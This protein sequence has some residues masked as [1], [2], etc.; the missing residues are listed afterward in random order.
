MKMIIKGEGE[1]TDI[2]PLEELA[3]D[4][5]DPEPAHLGTMGQVLGILYQRIVYSFGDIARVKRLPRAL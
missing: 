1:I 3:D 4:V 5:V 2:P